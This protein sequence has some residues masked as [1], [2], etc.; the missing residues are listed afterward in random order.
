MKHRGMEQAHSFRFL[1]VRAVITV[2]VV[3]AVLLGLKFN[4]ITVVERDAPIG[5][6]EEDVA[7]ENGPLISQS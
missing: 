6:V 7:R 3:L 5:V 1:V 2:A 4:G